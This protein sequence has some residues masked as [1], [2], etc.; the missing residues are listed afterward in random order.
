MKK[1][2]R[3]LTFINVYIGTYAFSV[4]P[5]SRVLD[6]QLYFLRGTNMKHSVLLAA[7]VATLAVTACGKKESTEAPSG[8]TSSA[9]STGGAGGTAGST[10]G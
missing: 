10:S 6:L 2:Y 9:P 7:L 4:P 5:I 3:F 1:T 8:A